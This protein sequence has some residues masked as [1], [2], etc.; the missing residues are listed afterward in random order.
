MS[1]RRH[2]ADIETFSQSVTFNV[3]STAP[4]TIVTL[5]HLRTST[6]L[7]KNKNKIENGI[8]K[9]NSLP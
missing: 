4:R 1:N 5:W 6:H 9:M 3:V 2:T 7:Y 8:V